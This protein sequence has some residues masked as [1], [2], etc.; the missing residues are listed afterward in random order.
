MLT[1]RAL[2]RREQQPELRHLDV[3]LRLYLANY[4]PLGIMLC[5]LPTLSAREV[6]APMFV[7]VLIPANGCSRQPPTCGHWRARCF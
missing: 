5:E 4:P 2:E 3:C 1:A 7:F 6:R